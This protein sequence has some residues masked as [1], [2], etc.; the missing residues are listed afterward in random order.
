MKFRNIARRRQRKKVIIESGVILINSYEA[1]MYE[2]AVQCKFMRH[3]NQIRRQY[4]VM[5]LVGMR[6]GGS[7]VS[8]LGP[9][10]FHRTVY[11]LSVGGPLCSKCSLRSIWLLLCTY[12][13]KDLEFPSQLIPDVHW[14]G[15]LGGGIGV[16][17]CD[18]S[19]NSPSMTLSIGSRP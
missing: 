1:L 13:A 15:R 5:K 19:R 10:A 18:T 9:R 4:C 16:Y 6:C 17:W 12:F 14:W 7:T 3:H 11:C 8:S 2:A